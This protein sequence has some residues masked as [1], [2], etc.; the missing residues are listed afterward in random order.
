M[1]TRIKLTT[2]TG[3][4]A[5]FTIVELMIATLVFSTI[6]V[7]I[8]FGV[9]S[10]T[11]SYYRGI[12]SSATQTTTQAALDAITQAIQFNAAGAQVPP[13]GSSFFCAGNKVFMYTLG[14]PPTNPVTSSS[15]GL[16]EA[17]NPNPTCSSLSVGSPGVELLTPNMRLTWLA[18]TPTSGGSAS[19]VSLSVTYGSADLMCKGSIPGTAV[20]ACSA[21][22]SAFPITANVT[23]SSAGDVH[24]KSQT[25]SQFCSTSDLFTTVQKRL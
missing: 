9:L 19:Q 3:S 22:A 10:F 16:F 20:G 5:G 13:P 25:G 23:G 2:K 15:W 24:C 8:T 21:G 17:D 6:L 12:N 18:V 11:K 1:H 7:V 4:Q 14:V